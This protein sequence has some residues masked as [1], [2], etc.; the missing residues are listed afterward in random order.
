MIDAMTASQ[1]ELDAGVLATDAQQGQRMLRA[2][3][4]FLGRFVAYPSQHAQTAH[5]LWCVHTHLMDVW[6]ST[7]RIALLSAEPASGKPERS[8]LPSYWFRIR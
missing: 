3:H 6:E 5:A 7:P 2:V 1:A 8:R 4:D